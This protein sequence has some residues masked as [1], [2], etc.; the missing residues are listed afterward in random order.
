MLLLSYIDY[1]YHHFHELYFLDKFFKLCIISILQFMIIYI[2]WYIAVRIKIE[3]YFV[4]Q[5]M[6]I[7]HF[8]EKSSTCII[9]AAS[10]KFQTKSNLRL[11]RGNS[12]RVRSFFRNLHIPC[13]RIRGEPRESGDKMLQRHIHD[14]WHPTISNKSIKKRLLK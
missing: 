11:S 2:T 3:N 10:S 9:S 14:F 1:F 5:Q 4:S 12:P 8:T 6:L 7:F 13:V